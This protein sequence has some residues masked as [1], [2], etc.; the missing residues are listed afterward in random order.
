MERLS[1]R[2]SGIPLFPFIQ[3]SLIKAMGLGMAL[4]P[5][6][7]RSDFQLDTNLGSGVAEPETFA[8]LAAEL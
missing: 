5:G 2:L 7:I 1:P 8:T 4:G 6:G 3:P